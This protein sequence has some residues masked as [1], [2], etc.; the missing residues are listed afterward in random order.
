VGFVGAVDFI[1]SFALNEGF[2]PDLALCLI[3]IIK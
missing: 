2:T 1:S 3:S